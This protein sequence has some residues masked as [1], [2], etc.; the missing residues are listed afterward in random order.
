MVNY[1]TT[2]IS[3]LI[4]TQSKS[5]NFSYIIATNFQILPFTILLPAWSMGGTENEKFSFLG[6]FEFLVSRREMEDEKREIDFPHF[7][8]IFG[9]ILMIFYSSIMCLEHSTL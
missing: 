4:A 6:F 8:P 1:S 2:N 3:E 7:L 5:K 9:Q